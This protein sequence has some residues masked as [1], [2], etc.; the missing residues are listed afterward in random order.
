MSE[1]TTPAQRQI[2]ILERFLVIPDV[3]ERMAALVSA[4][5]TLLPLL[6][7]QWTDE[8][9]VPGCVSR[10]WLTGALENGRCRIRME[11]ESVMVRGLARALCEIYDDATPEEILSTPPVVFE[12]LGIAQQLTPTRANGLAKIRERIRIFA[13]QYLKP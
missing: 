7:E 2:R 3:H 9:L 12:Q 10:V 5:T 1:P 4:R 8:N 6:P 13:I 11:A